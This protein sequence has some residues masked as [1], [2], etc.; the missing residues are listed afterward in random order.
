MTLVE[1]RSGLGLAK[2]VSAKSASVISAASAIRLKSY[3]QMVRT[4]T[5]DNGLK[6]AG[7]SSIVKA[8]NC[9]V[10]FARPYASW[11]RGINENYNGLLRQYF[12]KRSCFMAL[13]DERRAS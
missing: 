6:F 5:F 13:A 3:R 12:P 4:P 7:H 9:K 10:F 11:Q 2:K 8:L 1:R